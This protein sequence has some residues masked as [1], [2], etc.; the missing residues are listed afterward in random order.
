VATLRSAVPLVTCPDDGSLYDT[1]IKQ[2]I[3][4]LSNGKGKKV[5]PVR[6]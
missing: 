5:A 1:A 6:N 4:I 2:N 3:C